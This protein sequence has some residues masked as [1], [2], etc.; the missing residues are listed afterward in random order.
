MAD[1][2]HR[3]GEEKKYLEN[4]KGT[5]FANA[6]NADDALTWFARRAEAFTSP[7]TRDSYSKFVISF[8][9]YLDGR[10]IAL[11]DI[12]PALTEDYRQWLIRAGRS[13][14]YTMRLGKH[15]RAMTRAAVK[16]GVAQV[17]IA[18]AFGWVEEVSERGVEAPAAKS[19]QPTLRFLR[20][21]AELDLS[22]KRP[23]RRMRDLLLFAV[24]TG[25]PTPDELA[26]LRRSDLASD[27]LSIARPDGTLTLRL[28]PLAAQ[29]L[30]RIEAEPADDAD[31]PLLDC[32]QSLPAD[33]AASRRAKLLE[34]TLALTTCP[35]ADAAEPHLA[36]RLCERA[37]RELGLSLDAVSQS[38]CHI[39]ELSSLRSYR[40]EPVA[41][42]QVDAAREALSHAVVDLRSRWYAVRMACDE[43]IFRRDL[44]AD[45]ESYYPMETIAVRIGKKL[46]EIA[47]P[48]LKRVIFVRLTDARLAEFV[49]TL[50]PMGYVYRAPSGSERQYAVIPD[51][52]MNRFRLIVSGGHDFVDESPAAVPLT[53]KARVRVTEGPFAGHDALV[54]SRIEGHRYRVKLLDTVFSVEYEAPQAFL[55]QPHP[56]L[57]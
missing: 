38:L 12:T 52:E 30:P 48:I 11:S 49:R 51:R 22:D 42:E 54:I 32:M 14:K 21:L 33:E 2:S 29:I 31:A 26:R 27:C 25:G 9:K 37:M 47:S 41:R 6:E 24:L 50:Y 45:I 43:D 10:R 23:L 18:A 53:P 19:G 44:P 34:L 36:A 55:S 20:E 8:G 46:K 7:A 16:E 15:F 5:F 40:C 56:T 39:P 1:E 35:P 17:D 4:K 28:S 3:R 13:R 57:P